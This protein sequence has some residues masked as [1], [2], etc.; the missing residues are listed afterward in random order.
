MHLSTVPDMLRGYPQRERILFLCYTSPDRRRL[1]ICR[2]STGLAREHTERWR[3]DGTRRRR[4]RRSH[5]HPGPGSHGRRSAVSSYPS[6]GRSFRPGG[7]TARRPATGAGPS[8]RALTPPA[9]ARPAEEPGRPSGA[10]APVSVDRFQ[11]QEIRE[12][13]TETRPRNGRGKHARFFGCDL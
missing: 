10:A 3:D 1:G 13:K 2:T 5:S 6:A 11:R 12:E 7:S 9:D 4:I 8:T